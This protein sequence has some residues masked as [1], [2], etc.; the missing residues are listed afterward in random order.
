MLVRRRTSDDIEACEAVFRAVHRLDG[1]PPCL[2]GDFLSFIFSPAVEAWVADIDGRV[3]GQVALHESG[4]GPVMTLASEVTGQPVDRLAVVARLA[5]A[6]EFRRQGAGRALLRAATDAA[7][8]KGFWPVLE[9]VTRFAGAISLYESCGWR[10]A[11]ELTVQ[12][13]DLRLDEVVFVGP[14]PDHLTDPCPEV[15]GRRRPACS[16]APPGPG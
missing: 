12:F 2:P 3:V 9:V 5:V 11:G 13:D 8:E 10:R 16:S 1:Y 4:S 7:L 6:P 14:R 15:R